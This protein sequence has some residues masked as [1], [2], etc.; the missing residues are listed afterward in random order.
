MA[1]EPYISLVT[2]DAGDFMLETSGNGSDDA[3]LP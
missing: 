3:K 1:A 2:L